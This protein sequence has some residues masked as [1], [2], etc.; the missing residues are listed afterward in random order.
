MVIDGNLNSLLPFLLKFLGSRPLNET[1]V[2]FLLQMLENKQIWK[3]VEFGAVKSLNLLLAYKG[4]QA[5]EVGV[6]IAQIVES[7]CDKYPVLR[8][9]YINI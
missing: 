9:I 7:L 3:A 4:P 6:K 1:G 8:D 5:F 2:S